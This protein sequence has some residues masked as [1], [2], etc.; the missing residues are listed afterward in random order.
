MNYELKIM[1]YTLCIIN[2]KNYGKD[3]NRRTGY[4]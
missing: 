4:E 2:Y 3:I 1:N